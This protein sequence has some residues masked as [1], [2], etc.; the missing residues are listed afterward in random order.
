M[1][2]NACTRMHSLLCRGVTPFLWW[3]DYNVHAR[4]AAIISREALARRVILEVLFPSKSAV[5]WRGIERLFHKIR[6]VYAEGRVA[7]GVTRTPAV[8]CPE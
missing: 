1:G 4:F 7:C 3:S 5:T 2:W 8:R 6:C